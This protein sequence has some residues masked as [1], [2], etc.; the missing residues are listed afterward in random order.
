MKRLRIEHRTTYTYP[1]PVKLGRHR[2]VIRPREG[3]DQRV[4]SMTLDIAPAH[5]RIWTCDIF[6]NNVAVVDFLEP[7]TQLEIASDV[8]VQRSAPFPDLGDHERR[9]I[10]W[11]VIYDPLE[12]T[13]T[14]VYQAPSYP[15]DMAGIRAWLQTELPPPTPLDA[16][17]MIIELTRLVQRKIQYLRRSEKGVQT[18]V[19]TL[20]L[21]T[22]SCR[23]MAT[24][25]MDAAR[26]LG[27]ACRFASGY[28]DCAASEAGRAATHA[29]NEVYFPSYGWR[30]FDPSTG[31][32][33]TTAHIVTGVSNHPRGVMPVS[34]L[35]SGGPDDRGTL[36]VSV[37]VERLSG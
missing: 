23:D 8:V 4:E 17:S 19:E 2:L 28:L 13:A 16:E 12:L 7:T 10:A 15:D 32:P 1:R 3:H 20:R 35:F 5:R 6:G 25:M 22:G 24:L 30:G 27:I 11:P 31:G 37:R 21:G 14:A 26:S 9:P 34:G 33:T 36:S 29:W 18:P